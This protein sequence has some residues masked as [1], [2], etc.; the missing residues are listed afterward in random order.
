MNYKS[1]VEVA[2][3]HHRKVTQGDKS[4]CV[5]EGAVTQDDKSTCVDEGAVPSAV[6]TSA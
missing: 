1:I 3:R 6:T 5:D 4:T 2:I